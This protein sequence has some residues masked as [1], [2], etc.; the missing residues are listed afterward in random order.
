MRKVLIGAVSLVLASCGGSGGP[1]GSP[2]GQETAVTLN[3][4]GPGDVND[5]LPLTPG[6]YWHYLGQSNL[7]SSYHSSVATLDNSIFSGEAASVL[8]E[9]NTYDDGAQVRNFLAEDGNGIANLGSDSLADFLSP[10]AT[11]YWEYRFPLQT[12][13]Q[14]V[15]LDRTNINLDTDLDDDFINERFD[16]VATVRVQTLGSMSVAAGSFNDVYQIQRDAQ[17]SLLLS[18]DQSRVSASLTE[19]VWLA[20][21]IGWIKR[22]LSLTIDGETE[23]QTEELNAYQV[24][25]VAVG[26]QILP[27]DFSAAQF[28]QAD[29]NV[30]SYT[31]D[32]AQAQLIALGQPDSDT[33][34]VPYFPDR[35][36]I[37]PGGLNASQPRFC[38]VEPINRRI[39]FAVNASTPAQYRLAIADMP[40]GGNPISEGTANNPVTLPAD[41]LTAGQVETRSTSFY[42]ATG[43]ITGTQEISLLGLE[44]NS[45][46]QLHVYS[47]NTYS[48]EL[49][50]TL[51]DQL[52]ICSQPNRDAVYFSVTSGPLN[53][54][55]AHYLL[56]VSQPLQ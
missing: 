47:D 54:D 31:T 7:A 36:L 19:Q 26:M 21:G 4:G 13:S 3:L 55:G 34:L 52:N 17:M 27:V 16:I 46:A 39:V 12:G 38:V 49:D 14:F 20:P 32:T 1:S 24:N 25:G 37:A 2:T 6:N 9:L 42:Q 28:D 23:T 29:T 10:Q 18:F 43:L 15:Q 35:C 45:V 11:A 44:S 51:R 33:V 5:Y 50:C 22:S 41:I 53:R 48:L 8:L 56:L 30:Y 40:T